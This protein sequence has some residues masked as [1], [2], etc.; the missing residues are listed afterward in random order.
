[1]IHIK[2]PGEHNGASGTHSPLYL[3]HNALLT[4]ELVKIKSYCVGLHALKLFFARAK[5]HHIKPKA[6]SMNDPPLA[7]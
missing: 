5:V 6:A 1:M 3:D 7:F 2:T 4:G